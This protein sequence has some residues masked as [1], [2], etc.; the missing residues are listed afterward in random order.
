MIH[1]FPEKRT[2]CLPPTHKELLS[3]EMC[4]DRFNAEVVVKE[5][6]AE[7]GNISLFCYD[8]K[9]HH[10]RQRPHTV[11][12]HSLPGLLVLWRLSVTFHNILYM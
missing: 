6:V 8:T 2:V 3:Q 7:L 1:A 10:I 5:E 4:L 11:G 12:T 9:V